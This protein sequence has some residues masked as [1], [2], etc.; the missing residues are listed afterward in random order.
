MRRLFAHYGPISPDECWIW[1]GSVRSPDSKQ[2]CGSITTG[3]RQDGTRRT[4]FT[5]TVLWE[6]EHDTS[7]PKGAQLYQECDTLCCNPA[8]RTLAEAV[9][10]A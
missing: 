2:K 4:R 3:S 9:A 6:A 7:L 5:H 10:C 1:I 8:H